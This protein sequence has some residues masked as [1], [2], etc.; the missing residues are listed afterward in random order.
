MYGI[1]TVVVHNL[2]KM[3]LKLRKKC[4]NVI[5]GM[6]DVRTSWY[7]LFC[8][9]LALSLYSHMLYFGHFAFIRVCTVV[10]QVLIDA[11]CTISIFIP[12]HVL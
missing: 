4:Y 12:Q 6:R 8:V 9:S 1:C 2:L 5:E 10:G 3:L 11:T 7:S